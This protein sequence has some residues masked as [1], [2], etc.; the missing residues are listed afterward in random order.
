MRTALAKSKN[1]ATVK[2]LQS[3]GAQYGQDYL[4]RFGFN[5]EDHP[6]YLTLALGAGVT[7]PLE[8]ARGYAVFANGGYLVHPYLI[9]R[10]EDYDGN[11]IV[12]ELDYQRRRQ[13]I[14]RRNAFM[15]T[16]MLQSVIKE[17]TGVA[18]KNWDATI[19]PV[20]P[21][22]PMIRAMLGFPDTAA[23]L[24]PLL[25]LVM[26]KIILWERKKRKPCGVAHLARFYESGLAKYAGSGISDTGRRNRRRY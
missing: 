2:L 18:A 23:M 10:V 26:T 17:G 1:L 5:R 14:D 24:L 11:E 22:P 20:K 9:A 3:I 8:M 4:T 16:S 13:V 7:T 12:R 21:A 25:G 15:M 6:P 19:W